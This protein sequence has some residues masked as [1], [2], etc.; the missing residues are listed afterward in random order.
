MTSHS[1]QG[2]TADRV[3]VNVD[4]SN[5]HEKLLN[6]RFAYVAISRARFD[7]RIYTDNAQSLSQ[8]LSREVSKRAA[9][10]NRQE[11]HREQPS[12]QDHKQKQSRGLS[13]GL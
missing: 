1:S 11:Q 5:A 8:E 6:T 9:I 10:E 4:T 3:L 12:Q 2:L 7:A 13:L